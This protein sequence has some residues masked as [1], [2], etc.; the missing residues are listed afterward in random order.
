MSVN[1][2]TKASPTIHLRETRKEVTK[3]AKVTTSVKGAANS[4]DVRKVDEKATAAKKQAL[5]DVCQMWNKV[6]YT[7]NKISLLLIFAFTLRHQSKYLACNK[8]APGLSDHWER[9]C[10]FLIY[11]DWFNPVK[12][13]VCS[14]HA[15]TYTNY[16]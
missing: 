13:S 6:L 14:R 11:D 2:R 1:G 16:Q 5:V 9:I 15:V 3:D 10:P 12:H 4:V 7:V 8:C